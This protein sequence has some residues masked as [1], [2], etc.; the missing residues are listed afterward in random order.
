[1][2]DIAARTGND[3]VIGLIED[4]V[5]TSPEFG[6]FPVRPISGI[7]YMVSRRVGRPRGGFRSANEGTDTSASRTVQELKQCYF[8]DVQMEVD[9]AIVRA[10]DGSVGDILSQEAL[11]AFEEN[12]TVIGSQVYYGLAADS[13]GFSG[14]GTQIA[15]DGVFAGG[16]TNT[17]SAFL[18]DL[19]LQG[20]HFVLGNGGGIEMP[21]WRKQQIADAAGKKL[22]AYVN[23]LS[24]YIGLQVGSEH[25]VYRVRGI[26]NASDKL[27]DALGAKALSNVPISRR[28]KG[29]WVWLMNSTAALSLQ[30]SR[31]SIGNVAAG[32]GGGAAFAPAP[33]ELA[34]I[35]I[36]LTD[37]LL[38]TE[39]TLAG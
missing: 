3:Q 13:K 24:A 10:D 28:G 5:T 16:T 31:S 20:V 27:T 8:L 29:T 21:E 36:V 23:N 19:S 12:V 26:N 39:T 22:T 34:G 33:T 32:A 15:V 18:V 38:N 11:G 35:P 6:R 1:M 7:T 30:E 37:A 2:L 17:T 14:L 9:E 25:S 4:V